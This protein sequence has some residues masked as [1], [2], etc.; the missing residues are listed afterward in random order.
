MRH[1]II[2]LFVMLAVVIT[3]GCGF[4]PRGTTQVP[5]ELKTLIVST[6]DPY[7][8]LARTVRQQLR[9]NDVKIVED[10]KQNRTDIPTLRL[11][12]ESSGRNTASVFISGT[13]AEYQ[14]VMTLTA[15]VLLPGKGIYPISTTVYRSFFDNPNA[16]LAKDAEQDLITQEM[17]QRAAE[18]LVRKLLTVHAAQINSKETLPA[19][20]IPVPGQG[21][22]EAPTSSATSLQ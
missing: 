17:R 18:Q 9:I 22:Q 16:A 20:V 12:P 1:P 6:G 19:S 5:S 13:A 14:L 2:R 8:P 15:Q 10:S 11:G 3:A 21:S 4:H 7:G